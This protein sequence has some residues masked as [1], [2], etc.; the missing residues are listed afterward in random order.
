MKT[1]KNL[2]IPVEFCPYCKS[3]VLVPKA[4]KS[5]LL[6]ANEVHFV[7]PSCEAEFIDELPDKRAA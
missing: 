6:R 5:S 7:C 2:R 3:T 1:R 4:V